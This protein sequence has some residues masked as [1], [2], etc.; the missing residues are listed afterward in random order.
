MAADSTTGG[1]GLGGPE[2]AVANFDGPQQQIVPL[3]LLVLQQPAV[4][5]YPQFAPAN[6]AAPPPLP[7]VDWAMVAYSL[8][9]IAE[10]EHRAIQD[11]H[12]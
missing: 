10:H 6:F 11:N 7:Q 5:P 2:A 1:R 9:L 4:Q 3:P 8:F 12:N